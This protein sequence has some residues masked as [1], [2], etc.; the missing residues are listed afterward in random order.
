MHCDDAMS[1]PVQRVAV[2][3]AGIVGTSI[4]L[5]LR[6]RGTDVMLVDRDEPGRG[7][8][9]GN[10]GA[11]SPASVAPVAMPGVL[12]SVP[13]ML[14][15]DESPLYLPPGYLPRAVPWLLRFVASARP[16]VVSESARKLAALH[17]D[18][19]AAHEAMTRELGVPELLLQRGHLHLY[20]D[21]AALAKDCTG[22]QMRSEYGFHCERIDRAAIVAMEPNVCSRYRIGMYMAD[23]ATI[24]NPFRYVQAMARGFAAQGGRVVR[25]EVSSLESAAGGWRLRGPQVPAES[26]DAVVVAAGAWSRRLLAPQGYKLAMESQRGYHLQFQGAHDTV[27]RTVVLADKKVFFTPME[28]GLRV[29]GTVEIG[30]LDAPPDPRRAAVL[31]RITHEAFQGLE[32]VPTTTWMGHRPCMPDSVPVVGPVPGRQG[33]WVATGHGHLGLTDSLST[34]TRISQ[35]MLG[36]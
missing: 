18:C 11:V 32:N 14:L 28:E 23:H 1:A 21:E 24:L 5:T 27:S 7:C 22:W 36:G 9:Y 35:Q 8:S 2:V 31:A 26:F 30:G 33:L 13:R 34:A 6:K 10:S 4:A 20:P 25:G 17:A 12:A 15:D 29:G 16:A 19:V 3:G